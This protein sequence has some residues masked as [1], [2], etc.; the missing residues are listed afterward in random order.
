MDSSYVSTVLTA[1]RERSRPLATR[2]ARPRTA[3]VLLAGFAALFALYLYATRFIPN[4]S[5]NASILLEVQAMAHGNLILHGWYLPP[6]SFI[7]SEMPLDAVAGLI[8]PSVA[9][10]KITPALLYAATMLGAVY[11]ALRCAPAGTP[12]WL[13]GGAC[14]AL[15]AFPTGPLF[16]MLMQGPMHIGTL[17]LSLL[18]WIA[19]DR[20][21]KR[22]ASRVMLGLFVLVTALAILGDPMAELLIVPPVGIVGVWALW[23]SRGKDW[24]ARMTLG[25]AVFAL[26]LGLGA[27]HLLMLTGT[28]IASTSASFVPL[29]QLWFHVLWLIAGVCMLFHINLSAGMGLDQRAL[30]LVLNGSFLLVGFAG[31]AYLFRRS[32]FP[33]EPL[34]LR[35]SLSRVL[36]WAIVCS[37]AVFV[38][39]DISLNI[40]GIRY[41][42]AVFVYAGILC[43]SAL[44][45]VIARPQLDRFVL[46][47]LAVS[48]LTFGI[49]LAQ[50]S[51]PSAPER[52]LIAFLR[53]HHLTSGFGSFWAANIVT[54]RSDGAVRVLPIALDRQHLF[55][56]RWHANADWFTREQL[57]T[58]QFVVVDERVPLAPFT[59]A[60]TNTFGTPDHV[61][62]V[63]RYTIFAWDHPVGVAATNLG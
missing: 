22:P 41:L 33:P 11:L 38:F 40:G 42:L 48:G 57:G 58:V 24:V 36:S 9:L 14:V 46:A 7:T 39:S 27:Q 37:F 29:D 59:Q 23:Q 35:D 61:Y 2:I 55:L 52:P 17:V 1:L 21:V 4:D 8:I 49:Y 30:F 45:Q 32:L 13:A 56:Y 34:D 6:D 43:S 12:R 15:V 10:L 60:V 20:F 53:S 62:Q 19:Y 26:L 31:F 28:H 54:L 16:A 50:Q 25:G 5:D 44:A 18:A 63:D 47:F 51:L 3:V